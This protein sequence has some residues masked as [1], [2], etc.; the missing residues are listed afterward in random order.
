MHAGIFLNLLYIFI[1]NLFAF[2]GLQQPPAAGTNNSF[3]FFRNFLAGLVVQTLHG[4]FTQNHTNRGQQNLH[5]V[6]GFRDIAYIYQVSLRLL[7]NTS[8]YSFSTQNRALVSLLECVSI[9]QRMPGTH[10]WFV[11]FPRCL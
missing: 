6:I 3:E 4:T 1:V 11:I 5:P 10:L 2:V 8:S 7:P 9:F